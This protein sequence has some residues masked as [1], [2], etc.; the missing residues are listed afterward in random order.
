MYPQNARATAEHEKSV[1]LKENN[2]L[3]QQLAQIAEFQRSQKAESDQL[4]SQIDRSQTERRRVEQEMLGVVQQMNALSTTK[5]DLD[6][7]VA[8]LTDEKHALTTS[9]QQLQSNLSATAIQL[10]DIQE[11]LE[12]VRHDFQAAVNERDELMHA[13]RDQEARFAHDKQALN[14]QLTEAMAR[15]SD[16]NGKI[17]SLEHK[18]TLVQVRPDACMSV[19]G[20]LADEP[21]TF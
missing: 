10:S 5:E 7:A 1:L 6:D 13:V 15:N 21:L 14:E 8:R 9:V 16:A 2:A 11:A 3:R 12:R 17:S 20:D 4:R 18:L 19:G